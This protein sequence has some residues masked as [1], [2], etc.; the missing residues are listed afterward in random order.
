MADCPTK[1]GDR[2]RYSLHFAEGRNSVQYLLGV[3][4]SRDHQLHS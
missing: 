3:S 4:L 1:G 2:W